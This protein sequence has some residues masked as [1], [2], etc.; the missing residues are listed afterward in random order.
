MSSMMPVIYVQNA[1]SQIGSSVASAR[2]ACVETDGMVLV[3]VAGKIT[4]TSD[5]STSRIF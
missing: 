1:G 2:A 4:V 3:Q 5:M